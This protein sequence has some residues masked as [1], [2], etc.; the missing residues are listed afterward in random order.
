LTEG[1]IWLW[2]SLEGVAGALAGVSIGSL[3]IALA[4]HALKLAVR[5]R[6]WQNVLRAAFPLQRVRYADAAVPYFAGVGAGAVAPFGGGELLKVML[7][8]TRLRGVSSASV[9]GSLAVEKVLDLVVGAAIVTVAIASGVRPGGGLHAPGVWIP[10]SMAGHAPAVAGAA[11]LIAGSVW[12][13]RRR[14][15]KLAVGFGHGLRALRSPGRYFVTVA[16][17]QLLSWLLR[18]AALYWL[19]RAFHIP[20]GIGTTLLVLALQL[21]AGLLPLTPGGAGTQ[22]A[23]IALSLAGTT[24]GAALVG[25]SAGSQA[26]TVVLDLALGVVALLL[27]GGSWRIRDLA[28][29]SRP[30]AAVS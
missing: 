21:L 15:V 8:R 7:L 2:A 25:F 6:V 14:V 22:Q 30:A 3:A 19:L 18:I 17:W 27:S 11:A 23:L 20:G 28:L 9:V 5:T 10:A 16:S 1:A 26:A 29:R 13:F 24:S 12:L 4:L